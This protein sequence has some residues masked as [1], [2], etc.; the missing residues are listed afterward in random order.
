MAF[1]PALLRGRATSRVL[2]CSFAPSFAGGLGVVVVEGSPPLAV[3][4]VGIQ[5]L[6]RGPRLCFVR[7][8]LALCAKQMQART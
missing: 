7:L 3:V 4:V 5:R 6:D 1:A 2:R 8:P